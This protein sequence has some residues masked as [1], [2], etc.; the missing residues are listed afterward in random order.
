M[1]GNTGCKLVMSSLFNAEEMLN[2]QG[3]CVSCD[4]CDSSVA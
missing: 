2:P 1:W 3:I 4:V